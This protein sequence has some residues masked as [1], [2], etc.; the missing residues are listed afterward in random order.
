MEPEDN[1]IASLKFWNKTKASIILEFYSWH[2]FLCKNQVFY[3]NW[4]NLLL[5]RNDLVTARNAKGMN[6]KFTGNDST[7]WRDR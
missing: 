2:F 5:A 3:I 1:E 4:D 7:E 6:V